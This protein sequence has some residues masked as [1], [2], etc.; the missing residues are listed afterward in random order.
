MDAGT[1][2]KGALALPQ[3]LTLQVLNDPAK[4]RLLRVPTSTFLSLANRILT[5]LIFTWFFLYSFQVRERD[6]MLFRFT[7]PMSFDF[8]V[9]SIDV[10]VAEEPLDAQTLADKI[11]PALCMLSR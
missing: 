10:L 5:Q 4:P 1:E 8:I 7:S 11:N 2:V 3:M 6:Y 9:V